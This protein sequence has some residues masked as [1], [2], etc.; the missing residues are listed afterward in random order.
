MFRLFPLILALAVASFACGSEGGP[1]T[2]TT[3]SVPVSPERAIEGLIGALRSGEY[4]ATAE[5]VD[6]SQLAIFAS[7][8][9][10]D[11]AALIEMSTAG[12]TS[13][14]RDNFWASF[15]E[16]I[17]GLAESAADD[18]VLVEGESFSAGQSD[19]LEIG[20]EFAQTGAT[21]TWILRKDD[22]GGWMVDVIATFGA[23]FVSPLSGWMQSMTPQER[24]DVAA[25]VAG[26]GDSWEALGSL[27][28]VDE[29]GVAVRGALDE[30]RL[31]LP[32]SP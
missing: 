2:T 19:Y 32:P 1:V 15:V 13:A 23:A 7:I 8:E 31:L 27:Q 30:L 3:T 6:E 9:S 16:A 28:G 14:V 26:H 22:A 21:G 4:S 10:G 20:A 18:I 29:A 5:Y 17:P 24:A 25:V 12:V 11:P